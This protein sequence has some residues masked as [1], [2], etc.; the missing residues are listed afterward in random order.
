MQ[1]PIFHIEAKTRQKAS[2]C[3]D[4]MFQYMEVNK[5]PIHTNCQRDVYLAAE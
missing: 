4:S 3:V 5:K 1:R 2:V